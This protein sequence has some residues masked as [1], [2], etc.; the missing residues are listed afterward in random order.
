MA[1]VVVAVHSL[2]EGDE[3]LL[4]HLSPR[5]CVELR[6]GGVVLLFVPDEAQPYS[7]VV[8]DGSTSQPFVLARSENEG[9]HFRPSGPG[10]FSL[11]GVRPRL[12][13]ESEHHHEVCSSSLGRLLNLRCEPELLRVHVLRGATVAATVA[14]E[15]DDTPTSSGSSASSSRESTF[16]SSGSSS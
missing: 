14:E 1:P 15:D 4:L 2:V 5:G 9:L 10:P 8:A 13:S 3:D 6:S 7:M 12:P 11:V 16:D